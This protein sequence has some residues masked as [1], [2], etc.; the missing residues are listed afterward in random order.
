MDYR[1]YSRLSQCERPGKKLRSIPGKPIP[2]PAE[3]EERRMPDSPLESILRIRRT[4]ISGKKTIVADPL[5]RYGDSSELHPSEGKN[6]AKN[7]SEVRSEKRLIWAR[8]LKAEAKMM[9][10]LF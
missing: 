3:L 4:E 10:E 2:V 7:H 8:D 5:F 9:T 1:T 6:P